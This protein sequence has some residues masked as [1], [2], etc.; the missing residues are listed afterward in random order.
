MNSKQQSMLY[1]C[2]LMLLTGIVV[3]YLYM[4]P[5]HFATHSTNTNP[6]KKAPREH[7][8]N[9]PLCPCPSGQSPTINSIIS[10]FSGIG[11]NVTQALSQNSE[12]LYQINVVP[13]SSNSVIGSVYAVDNDNKLTTVILNSNDVNQL[14]TITEITPANGTPINVVKPYVQKVTGIDYALQYENGSLSL[15]QYNPDFES[16]HWLTSTTTFNQGI[17]V[18]ANRVDIYT[19]EFAPVGNFAIGS[20][21]SSTLEG[22][23]SQQVNDVINLIKAGVQQYMSQLSSAT[24][25][26]GQISSS[27]LG[28][29]ANPLKV[30]VNIGG[31]VSGISKFEDILPATKN[32]VVVLLDQYEQSHMPQ[33]NYD[34]Y[35]LYK[36]SDL[37]VALQ[38]VSPMSAPDA[39]DYVSKTISTCNCKLN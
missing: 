29:A 18:V 20:G 24:N 37:E 22:K 17:P 39:R 10:K 30:N 11:I 28:N 8:A 25:G 7:F 26:T 2:A 19:P 9:P 3:Y 5:E 16:Q 1:I 34:N 32:D 33:L 12:Q 6:T 35:R 21:T 31:G 14:W 36:K 13:V 4:R 38:K 15:R 27:S 23:N